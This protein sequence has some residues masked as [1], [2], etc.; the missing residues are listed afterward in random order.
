MQTYHLDEVELYALEFI[1][2]ERNK[3]VTPESLSNFIRRPVEGGSVRLCSIY[4]PN[5]HYFEIDFVNQRVVT[6]TNPTGAK[7]ERLPE[8]I[9]YGFDNAHDEDECSCACRACEGGTHDL[10]DPDDTSY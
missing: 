1:Y 3:I 8:L 9:D 5:E 7:L 4:R 2:L 10:C 6:P